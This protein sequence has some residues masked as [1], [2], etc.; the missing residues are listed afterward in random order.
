LPTPTTTPASGGLT[1]SARVEFAGLGPLKLGMTLDEASAAAGVPIVMASPGQC[2]YSE[3]AYL[4]TDP[5]P[6][7]VQPASV[8]SVY[9]GV[10]D[11]RIVNMVINQRAW[12]T[13][14]DVG[15]GDTSSQILAA[16]PTA[17]VGKTAYGN[18]KITATAPTGAVI[19]FIGD[20]TDDTFGEIRAAISEAALDV[21]T[22]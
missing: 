10:K 19:V 6:P 13:V 3:K 1:L 17:T 22:C 20:E 16:Y 5:F 21:G 18:P 2:N 11:G 4:Q 14:A 9:F 15:I 8:P 12:K 7:S